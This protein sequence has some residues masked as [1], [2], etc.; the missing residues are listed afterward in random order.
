VE[1]FK[2]PEVVAVVTADL[3]SDFYIQLIALNL[4]FTANPAHGSMSPR[5]ID[6]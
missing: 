6:Y 3:V 4:Y 1:T 5:I 2:Q